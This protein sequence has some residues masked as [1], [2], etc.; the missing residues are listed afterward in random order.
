MSRGASSRAERGCS[1]RR[2]HRLVRRHVRLMP[3]VD[4]DV[5][6]LLGG[7]RGRS[8]PQGVSSVALLAVH[9]RA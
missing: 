2:I 5:H 3:C 9:L 7:A 1:P 4:V 6:P 8:P